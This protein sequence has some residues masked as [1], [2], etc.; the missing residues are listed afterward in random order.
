MADETIFDINGDFKYVRDY[1]KTEKLAQFSRA[2]ARSLFLKPLKNTTEDVIKKSLPEIQQHLK[3][4]GTALVNG[5]EVKD[6]AW[7]RDSYKYKATV[8]NR[9]MKSVIQPLA[10]SV[11]STNSPGGIY[12]IQVLQKDRAWSDDNQIR[13]FMI[14]GRY[15]S[16]HET[17]TEG[18]MINWAQIRLI[19][20]GYWIPQFYEDLYKEMDKKGFGVVAE[21]LRASHEGDFP[22]PTVDDF[23]EIEVT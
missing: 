16:T 8:T 3:S 23:M 19:N 9:G 21:G 22:A 1:L 13:H 15:V 10:R 12:Y 11:P 17:F 7:Q 18:R 6:A 20:D 4:G 14:N 2:T 5:V